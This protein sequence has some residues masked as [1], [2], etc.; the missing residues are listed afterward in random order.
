MVEV[1]DSRKWNKKA[2][3]VGKTQGGEVIERGRRRCSFIVSCL[4]LDS[5]SWEGESI[6]WANQSIIGSINSFLDCT[7]TV[8]S[9]STAEQQPEKW[10]SSSML[11]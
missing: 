1:E 5:L 10:H 2:R 3:K 7:H 11:S 4:R 6:Q 9:T 8:H